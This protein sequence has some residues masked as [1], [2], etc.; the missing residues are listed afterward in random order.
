[1]PIRF[2]TRVFSGTPLSDEWLVR[3]SQY[4]DRNPRKTERV[5]FVPIRADFFHQRFRTPCDNQAGSFLGGL[6]LFTLW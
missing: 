6:P 4:E 5:C 1:M 2:F 3:R